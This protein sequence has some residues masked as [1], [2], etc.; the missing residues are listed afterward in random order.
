[1]HARFIL[2]FYLKSH[3]EMYDTDIV[4]AFALRAL[5]QSP[6]TSCV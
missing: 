1:M 4:Y 2:F 5:N 6:H 3:M